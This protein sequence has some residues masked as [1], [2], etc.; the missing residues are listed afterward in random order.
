MKGSIL[1]PLAAPCRLYPHHLRPDPLKENALIFLTV[2]SKNRAKVVANE[3]VHRELRNLW[4][5]A[6]QWIVG[7]YVLMEEHVH[8]IIALSCSNTVPLT[9]WVAWWKRL[10]SRAIFPEKLNWQKSFWDSRIRNDE[11]FTAKCSYMRANPVRK[12][13]VRVPSDWE[14]QGTIHRI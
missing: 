2:C 7:P 5:D 11:A 8:L 14:F 1:N 9:N 12:G 6:S 4:S 3:K 10:S 13:L